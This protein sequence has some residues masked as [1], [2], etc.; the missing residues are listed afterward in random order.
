MKK[1]YFLSVARAFSGFERSNSKPELVSDE[2]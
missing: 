2:L 1:K